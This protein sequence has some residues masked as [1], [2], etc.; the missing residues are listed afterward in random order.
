[1][2]EATKLSHAI[3]LA[4]FA[5]ALTAPAYATAADLDEVEVKNKQAVQQATDNDGLEEDLLEDDV[6]K[7]TV[8]GSRIRRSEFASASP[9]QIIN[10]ETSRELGMFDTADMLQGTS[11]AAG[12]Q[13][14]NSFGGFVLDNG[15]GSTTIGFRGLGANRTLVLINGKRMVSAGAGGA[16]AAADLSLVPSVMI[17]RIENLF[18]GA[19][20]V[21]G[22]DAVAGVSNIIL[23]QDVEGFEFDAGYS[24]PNGSGGEEATISGMYGKTYDNGSF[25]IGAEYYNKQAQ[26]ISENP[27]TA[28]CDQYIFEKRDGTRLNQNRT[29]GPTAEG[30]GECDIFPLT[31]R[32]YFGDTLWG[33]LYRTPGYTNTGIPNFSETTVPYSSGFSPLWFDGDSNGDGIDDIVF[34]D[35]KGDGFRD[36]SFNDPFYAY[37]L[38]EHARSGDL[39][40]KNERISVVANGDYI[41]QDE[42]D[43]KV[44]FEGMYAQ[45][46]ND[47]FSPGGQ[48][49]PDV[50]I[51]NAYNPCG[52]GNGALCGGGLVD[53]GPSTATPIIN[54]RGDRDSAETN[55]SQYRIAAGVTANIAALDDFA[56]GNWY[57]D[58][59]ATYASSTGESVIQGI[60]A[61][62]F[63]HSLDTTV[64]NA[65]GSVTCGDGSDGCV[66]VNLFA[67]NIYQM[68]GGTFTAEEEAYLFVDRR[69]ET[70]ID[71]AVLNGFIGGD[72]YSLPWNDEIISGIVGF[73]YRKDTIN[74]DAN[75]VA[76]EGLLENYF[77][78]RG[79]AGS[80][81]LTELF[82]EI[83]LPLLKGQSFA[84]ELTVTMAGRLTKESFF[85]T[86]STYS[87]GAVYRPVDWVTLRGT[88]GTSFRAPDLR[89]RFI[90]GTTGF[91]SISDSCVVPELARTVTDPDDL[92]S[93]EAYDAT[94]DTRLQ[95]TLDS[96]TANGADPY[97]LGLKADGESGF[98]SSTSVESVTS[99]TEDLKPETSISKTWGVIL[100][101]PFSEDFELTVG[102][103]RFDIEITNSIAE[104]GIGYVF[105]QC[106]NNREEP[107]GQSEFCADTV[108]GSDTRVETIYPG[109]INIGFES[110][111][112]YDYNVYYQQD[113]LIGSDSL[114]VSLDVSATQMTEQAFDI[115]GSY[116]DNVGEVTTPEWRG[117]AI[118]SM[119]YSDFTF[120]WYTQFIGGGEFDDEYKDGWDS[121][122]DACT[123]LI[124]N[125]AAV[126]C[127]PIQETNNYVKHTAS[128]NWQVDNYSVT[129]G[130]RNVFD[131]EPE[132]VDANYGPSNTRNI[133]LGV[134]YDFFGR[135]LFLN[136]AMR[137]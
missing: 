19:S 13:I 111:K 2:I 128:I 72:F 15:P 34:V 99:G 29:T 27:F 110:S 7:I 24:Q 45:R 121:E 126:Q 103:T 59:Y 95:Y 46:N 12:A 70:T 66:P 113:F 91:S 129:F 26:A 86:E 79:A 117:N 77:A 118:L 44:Y 11:Q 98:T 6:E 82:T 130:A 108:R 68:G 62:R 1:M 42:N 88:K 31:N 14:D 38:S 65:D 136:F 135:S 39:T 60:H 23:K 96:C 22:S 21:Y 109:F 58:V 101:Q 116:D 134:G 114:G 41:F 5:G 78:D 80:R 57:Y 40:N 4:L 75:D 37:S 81:D 94:G 16:P 100:E 123:G 133:P 105:G 89:E 87:F 120:N 93:D 52:V 32:V 67:D 132:L 17:E 25:S 90:L 63:H 107:T 122:Y 20:T 106:Y 74:T 28:G 64:R 73:E 119:T 76:A 97:T 50:G 127:R 55:V 71:Q 18:D 54:I 84:E 43:T 47:S 30:F 48:L 131:K 115:L 56:E 35:G 69:I 33:S 104:P 36:V 3:R 85:D 112:G 137:M 8:T 61:P 51:N 124:E 83:D 125:G 10:G 92:D 102:F 53:W 49:F 9:V